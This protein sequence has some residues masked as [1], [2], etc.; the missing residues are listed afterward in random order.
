L[1]AACSCS[2][3]T[4]GIKEAASAGGDAPGRDVGVVRKQWGGLV[5][6]WLTDA[7]NFGALVCLLAVTALLLF[8][9]VM[10]WLAACACVHFRSLLFTRAPL[11]SRC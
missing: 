1:R 6:E 5:K 10:A 11:L 9:Y 2:P 3:W 7:D 4:F 8:P